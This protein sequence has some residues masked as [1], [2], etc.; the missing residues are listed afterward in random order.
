[1]A[2]PADAPEH[3]KA[4]WWRKNVARLSRPELAQLTGFSVSR[5]ADI[6]AGVTRSTGAPIDQGAMNRY[7]MACAAVALG[8]E[9]DWLT[10]SLIPDMPVEIRMF[11]ARPPAQDD[12]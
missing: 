4:E 9:F 11:S 5:I 6:E 7:R 1:M 12:D 2:P 8:V 10:L 3:V